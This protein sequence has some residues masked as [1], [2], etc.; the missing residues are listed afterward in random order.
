VFF[1]LPY[2]TDR[3]RRRTPYITYALFAANC[4]VYFLVELPYWQQGGEG[5][6]P[7][8]FVPAQPAFSALVRSM[9][10]HGGFMHLAGNMLFLWLFGSVVEDVL[11]PLLFLAFYF[12][13]QMGATLLDVGMAQAF[14]PASLEVPRVGASGA[15]AGILG[16]SAVCFGRVRVR[17]FYLVG[18]LLVWRGGVARVQ[19][20]FFLGAWF[21]YQVLAGAVSTAVGAVGGVAYWAHIGGFGAGVV[22]ALVL[23]LPGRIR[24]LDLLSSLPQGEM[25]GYQHYADLNDM[26]RHAPEDAEAWLAL[27]RSKEAYGFTAEATEAY[28]RAASLFLEHHDPVRAARAYQAVLHYD[29]GFAFPPA[30]QFDLAVGF[31]RAGEYRRALTAL[32][33]LLRAY[34]TSPEAE[35]SLL[36][37]GELAEKVR[38]PAMAAHY[39]GELL[40]RY[41]YST[42]R[43]YVR[44]KLGSLGG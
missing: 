5:V 42:W 32:D 27:A 29:P 24:R 35:V 44:Q 25:D 38:E 26:V 28:V 3:P 12:G 2:A 1:L 22:G 33:N 21:A 7:F 19:A 40:R 30:P 14:A 4:L 43:D 36:R 16:L 9:F 20:W 17:V 15:I 11:G 39:Y 41:P 18:L 10:S 6:L 34:P 8:G 37:A 23:A 31:A 13:G